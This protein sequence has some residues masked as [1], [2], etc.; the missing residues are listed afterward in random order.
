MHSIKRNTLQKRIIAGL[1][2]VIIIC[3]NYNSLC[4]GKR[5]FRVF[6]P[7]VPPEKQHGAEKEKKKS[8]PGETL[9]EKVV[10]GEKKLFLPP[11]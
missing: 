3:N 2:S 7:S 4:R 9:R 1:Q 8:P 11:L 10:E 6:P 5:H